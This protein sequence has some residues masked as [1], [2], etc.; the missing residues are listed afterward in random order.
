M[1][2]IF[3]SYNFENEYFVRRVSYH[4]SKQENLDPFCWAD[5]GRADKGF[6]KQLRDALSISDAFVAFI[7]EK[8]GKTQIQEI[9]AADLMPTIIHRILATFGKPEI[10]PEIDFI[11]KW[12]PV[13]I[14]GLEEDDALECAERIVRYLGETWIPPDGI[15]K[16]YIFDYEKDII[17]AY[18]REG[19]ITGEEIEK[20]CPK[21]WPKVEKLHQD[22]VDD[23]DALEEAAVGLYRDW[24]Y[25]ATGNICVKPRDP[26][27][28][29][30]ALTEFHS[31]CP[32]EENMTF[33]EAGPRRSLAYPKGHGA[34][35]QVGILVSGGIAPGINAVIAGIVRR[36]FM[37]AAKGKYVGNLGVKAYINGFDALLRRGGN[38]RLLHEND[39][40]NITNVGGSM[41]GSSRVE[42]LVDASPSKR[43]KAL[44]AIAR[45]VA[46]D[47]QILY[48][49]GGHGSMRAAHAIWKTARNLNLELS[50]V[51]IPKTMDNDILWV[52]QSFGFMSAVDHAKQLIEY[53]NTEVTSYPG[54]CVIQ[55]FGSDSGFVAAHAV[56]ASGVCDLCLI[57]EAKFTMGNVSTYIKNGLLGKHRAGENPYGIIVMAEAAVPMDAR[58]YLDDPYVG[59]TDDEKKEVSAY[60]EVGRLPGHTPD[61]LRRGTLKIVSRVLEREISHMPGDI[62]KI[63]RVITNEPKHQIRAIPPSCSDMIFGQ[64]LGSLA[65]DCAMAGYT[66]FMISQW[67]TEYV[68][69][70]LPLVILGRKRIPPQGIFW[71]TTKAS[72]G[73]P[74]LD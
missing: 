24:E 26:R 70:P 58:D 22:N 59:L 47:V 17:K 42:Q 35:L 11:K 6:D 13:M 12:S 9:M 38:F 55:L 23:E 2:T 66:D 10:P 50:V 15:P 41:I 7:G 20:G 61:P 73:Q 67:L 51:A 39:V 52:W 69:V 46:A 28:V 43:S 32:K 64:R 53:M 72:T 19:G 62:W 65:V 29:P 21:E 5:K 14:D 31:K 1:I 60:L 54:L 71:K 27:V 3:I 40:D 68:M 34:G 57:P 45:R 49:I 56:Q 63:F 37:Y 16:S 30:A 44:E 48:V 4:L 74:D 8:V 36:Q 25:D 33:P 18:M